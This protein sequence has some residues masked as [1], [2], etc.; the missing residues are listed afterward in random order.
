MAR[1]CLAATMAGIGAGLALALIAGRLVKSLLVGVSARDVATLA[2]TAAV[3][4][5]V[6]TVAASGPAWRAAQSDPAEI[7]RR[8]R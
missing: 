3:M 4:L 5:L 1:E 2:A 6:G 7:L 8:D